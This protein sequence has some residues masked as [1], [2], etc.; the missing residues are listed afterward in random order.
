MTASTF[1]VEDPS[2]AETTVQAAQSPFPAITLLP[3]HLTSHLTMTVP[4]ELVHRAAVAEVM[5]TGWQRLD[6]TRFTLSAQW[7]RGHSFFTPVNGTHHDPLIAAETIRQAGSLLSHAEFGVPFGHQFLMEKLAL[8]V[9]PDAL[10]IGH[11]PAALDID[12]VCTEVKRRGHRLTGMCYETTV[13]REGRLTAS[14]RISFT[15]ITPA[16]Y[17]RL[18]PPRVLEADFRPLPLTAPVAPETVG[19]FSPTDV[20]LSPPP[21]N[22]TAGSCAW[23]PATPSSSTTRSTTSPAW[24]SSRPPGK[25]RPRSS[26]G[27]C[28]SR[29]SSTASSRSTWSWTCPA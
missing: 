25:R 12:V 7:P 4:R 20:V 16:V 19:R 21:A 14:G 15:V 11:A 9:H 13:R 6:D 24:P 5:L 8:T 23:T 27:P 17:R 28:S 18:R 3:S 10:R 2:I 26:A 29:R 1:Q 22:R